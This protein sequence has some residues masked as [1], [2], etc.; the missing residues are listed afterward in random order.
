MLFLDDD[1]P[2]LPDMSDSGLI[3]YKMP[4]AEGRYSCDQC[5]YS[6]V[7]KTTLKRHVES[8]HEGRGS[9]L[10]HLIKKAFKDSNNR[11]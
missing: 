2:Y 10:I 3:K 9:F 4:D 6:A 8:K 5:A 11:F 7:S 1:A